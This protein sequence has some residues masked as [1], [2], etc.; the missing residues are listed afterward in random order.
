MINQK[1]MVIAAL[2]I[3]GAVI[4][5][6]LFFQTDEAKIKKNFHKLAERVEK[7]GD[8]HNLIAAKKAHAIEQLFTGSVRIQIPSYSVDKTFPRNGISPHVLFART[9]Y[10]KITIKFYDFQIQF[11]TKDTSIVE[12]TAVFKATTISGEPVDEV[13]EAECTLDKID[14]EWLFTGIK[15]VDVLER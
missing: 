14:N 10:K 4:V 2:L 7:N 5:F 3:A 1:N 8:E 12:L 6:F 13:H 11:P 15:G 9:R